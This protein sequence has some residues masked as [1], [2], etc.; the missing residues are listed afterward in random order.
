MKLNLESIRKY[1]NLLSMGSSEDTSCI[2]SV[3]EKSI[4][5]SDSKTIIKFNIDIEFNDKEKDLVLVIPKMDL[6]HLLPYSTSVDIDSKNKYVTDTNIKGTFEVDASYAYVHASLKELF[7]SKSEYQQYFIVN[8]KEQYEQLLTATRFTNNIDRNSQAKFVF[9]QNSKIF[10]SSLYRIYMRDFDIET[11]N[12]ISIS[13]DLINVMKNFEFPINISKKDNS[14]LIVNNNVELI[15]AN[16]EKVEPIGIFAD[17]F[18]QLQENLF[19]QDKI[20]I[21]AQEF[22]SKLDYLKYYSKAITNNKTHF[23]MNNKI[24]SLEVKD[25]SCQIEIESNVTSDFYFNSELILSALKGFNWKESDII[26]L[27]ESVASQIFCLVINNE[28]KEY[29]YSSKLVNN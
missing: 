11:D 16:I 21:N 27:Y 7:D 15:C 9:I 20:V 2:L 24:I 1:S 28:N 19:N 5:V 22:I 26:T 13:S 8:S 18:V 14:I 29:F 3:K 4:Y 10:S 6:L 23:N 12:Y 17:N 25:K